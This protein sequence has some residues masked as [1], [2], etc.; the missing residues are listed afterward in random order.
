MKSTRVLFLISGLI[1]MT[2]ALINCSRD[3]EEDRK[4]AL[5]FTMVSDINADSLEADIVWLQNMGT[6]FSLADNHK[7][8]AVK[9]R[10]R[11]FGMGYTDANLDSFSVTKTYRNINYEQ[12]QY[13]VTAMIE[14]T[15]YPDS[16]C[17]LGGHYDNNL[18]SD[19][20]FINVPGQMIMPVA[21][22][23]CW[24]SRE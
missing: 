6:R 14:G 7:R 8:V 18:A 15:E 21:L 11:L 22:L 10:N 2:F 9:I 12:W 5:M 16:L 24:R 19:D 3:S 17:I 13:N 1:L 23:P 4:E 20:P